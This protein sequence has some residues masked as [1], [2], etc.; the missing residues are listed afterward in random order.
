M[1][2]RPAAIGAIPE[3]TAR[4][5]RAAFPKGN[6]YV[7]MRD[8]LGPLYADEQF[9]ALF[10]ARGR[11]VEAPWR[12]ALVL[13]MQFA[14][15]LS[16]RRAADAVRARID[17]KYALGLEL[18]DPGFDASVLSEFRTRLV[19]GGAEL[20][21]LDTMLARFRA[22]G[23]LKARGRQRTDSTHV[24][25]A[26]RWLNR[27]AC[28][29]ETLRHAL[30]G[31]AAAA[32]DWLRARSEPGWV[33]RYGPRFDDYRLPKGQAERQA[34]AEVIGADG[35]GVLAAVYAAEAPPALRAVPAVETL[36]RVWV[37]QYYAP[38]PDGRVRW[39]AGEDLPPAALMINSP[40]DLEARYSL[41]RG[42][43]WT[44][45]KAH[46]TETCDP[47]AP[48]LV[49]H[50]ETTPATT[51]DWHLA[52][53]IHAALARK[54]LLPGE[55]ILDAGYVDGEV[56]LRS[57]SEYQ[58]TVVGPV[59]PD[60]SWQ[61]QAGQGFDVAC[62]S[63]DWEARRATCP[64]GRT[65]TKWSETHDQRNNP[66]VNIRFSPADC[67]VC[68]R[69]AAC[70]SSAAGPRHLTVRPRAQH[71]ALQAARQHQTSA[72]FKAQYA[73]RAGVEGTLSQALRVCD[74]RRARYIGL[75]KTRLQHSL[76]AAALNLH[77]LG[78]WWD[79]HPFATTRRS[80]FV[81][82]VGAAP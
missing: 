57:R 36:R 27:L 73:A 51:P 70:T 38:E 66:I 11:P 14:E 60:P 28:V 9:A 75:A 56:L 18:T 22:A 29:G 40:Y 46:L 42:T 41:K 19:E 6:V 67:R 7:R 16:D 21:L 79:E 13:V 55:H 25:A 1:S 72:A 81:A 2:L 82:L 69:R 78:A 63:L 8:E 43:T 54:Q 33:E 62:F 20:R 45:Y 17:W 10:P 47:D 49:T 68:P 76:T 35:I 71:E 77:R 53:V 23:L 52:P 34:L 59:P 5:A 65:S 24:L 4:V 30:N 48:H 32:P 74:L 44:G 31:L 3:E 15:G 26:I 12:L 50:V 61:A 37:Q 58:V 64:A 39:R 80:P